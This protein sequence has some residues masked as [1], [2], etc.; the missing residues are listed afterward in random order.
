MF[1]RMRDDI[2]MVFE[3]DPAAKTSFEVVTTYAGLHAVWNHLLAHK[4]YNKKHYVAARII[5][6]IS[7]FFTGIEIHPGAKIGKRLFIDHGMG[8]VI[9]ETCTIGDNVTIY[10][11]V[12]L[13]GTGKEKGKRHP[14]IGDNVLIAAGSKILGNIK[15]DS[16]VNIGA[17]SVVLTNVP[18]YSTV[19]G[20]PGHIVKQH[21][22][23]IG[24]NFD[25]LNLPDPIY[26]QMKQ[27]EK[28]LEQVKNGEIQDDYI[29]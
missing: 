16:N 12:T 24:K 5:S 22:K 11:G 10:Q 23:R 13:G 9:G 29:I 21:G 2:K 17:N 15:V 14:D 25:H 19:V 6:Q 3:Q 7:R 4:L 28:Q 1:K 18:S 26:E 20:I 27:L 8:V